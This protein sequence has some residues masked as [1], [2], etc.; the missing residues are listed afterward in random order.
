MMARRPGGHDVV[1]KQDAGTDTGSAPEDEG[2]GDV[3][4]ATR[5][6]QASLMGRRAAA[7]QQ[8]AQRQL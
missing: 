8:V 6:R 5:R 2:S 7:T 1:H 4:P 3:G